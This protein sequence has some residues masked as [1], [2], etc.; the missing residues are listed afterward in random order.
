M[1]QVWS[2]SIR[3]TRRDPSANAFLQDHRQL[4]NSHTLLLH[5]IAIAQ[6]DR[7]AES[8]VSFSERLEING[9]AKRSTYFVLPAIPP[10]DR[11]G[12]V[13]K[14][15]HVRPQK[16]EDLLRFRHERLLILQQRKNRTLN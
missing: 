9:N 14:H 16:G 10:T 15:R 12:L 1:H 7:F 3:E 2:G 11:A 8:R 4:L 6:R 5:R 13:V